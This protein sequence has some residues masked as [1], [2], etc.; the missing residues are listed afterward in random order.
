[1][2]PR[3]RATRR[4]TAAATFLGVHDGPR[5]MAGST[6]RPAGGLLP[7][8][9]SEFEFFT[10]ARTL[11]RVQPMSALPPIADITLHFRYVPNCDID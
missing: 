4:A 6:I 11:M 3:H 8:Q 10:R 7:F 9:H 1:M 2:H 5:S